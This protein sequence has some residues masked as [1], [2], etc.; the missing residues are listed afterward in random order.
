MYEPRR[1][2]GVET[3]SWEADGNDHLLQIE[4]ADANADGRTTIKVYRGDTL[5]GTL[6]LGAPDAGPTVVVWRPR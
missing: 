5:E 3:M 6:I 4:S 1:V 2:T